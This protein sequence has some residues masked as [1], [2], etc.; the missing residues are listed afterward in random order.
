MKQ[1]TASAVALCV[2]ALLWTPADVGVEAR[3]IGINP[4][5]SARV[6]VAR[7][8]ASTSAAVY[9]RRGVT[10]LQHGN[11]KGAIIDFDA[12]LRVNRRY[13]SA[14]FGLGNAYYAEGR[15]RRAIAA[16]TRFLAL[17]PHDPYAYGA[18]YNRAL[19]YDAM[20]RYRSASADYTRCLSLQ[21]RDANAYLYR[22]LDRGHL[23]NHRGAVADVQEAER[24]YTAQKNSAGARQARA[25][26]RQLR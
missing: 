6:V 15:H 5:A 12:A 10:N 20:R 26:L 14:Y 16:Y 3:S 18:Y 2:A 9:Y 22:G 23:G 11:Y 7:P 19:N 17:T 8:R 1:W 4:Q 21:R 24:L 13:A 25:I